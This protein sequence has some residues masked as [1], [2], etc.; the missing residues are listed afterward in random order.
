MDRLAVALFAMHGLAP[1]NWPAE[2]RGALQL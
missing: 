1:R 2:V